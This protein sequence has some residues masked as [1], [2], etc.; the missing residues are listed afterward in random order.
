MCGICGIVDFTDKTGLDA[1]M[2][3]KMSSQMRHRGP[4]DEGVY[5]NSRVFPGS[6]A[7]VGLGHRRLSIIDLSSDGHQ[8]MPNEDKTLWVVLNGEIYNFLELRSDLEK[9]GHRFKSRSDTEI[10]VHLYEEYG[11]DCVKYLRGMFAF[12]LWDEKKDILL[13]ARDRVGKKPL[14]Y[15]YKEG[16]FCFASEFSA[17][18]ASNLIDKQINFESIDYYLTLGYVPAPLTIYKD[19]FKLPPAHILTLKGGDVSIKRYW[20][21]DYSDKIKI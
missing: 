11:E 21:L 12:G 14:I 13:L 5:L 16:V 19:I 7:K 15:Y 3:R 18:L 8:P 20:D 17:I 6:N 10:I 4:D 1:D 9:K 2:V